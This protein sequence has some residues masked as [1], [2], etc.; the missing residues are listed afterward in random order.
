MIVGTFV[1][2]LVFYPT[3]SSSYV[4]I[5]YIFDKLLGLFETIAYFY[6]TLSR[7]LYFYVVIVLEQET[8]PGP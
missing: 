1:F 5:Y 3:S 6:A 4:T 2:L 7:F 8:P